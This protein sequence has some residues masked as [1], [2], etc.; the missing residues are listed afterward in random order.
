MQKIREICR[1]WALSYVRKYK[2]ME[3]NYDRKSEKGW[4]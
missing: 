1:G 2:N 4:N 3:K